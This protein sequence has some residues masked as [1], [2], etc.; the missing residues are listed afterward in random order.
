MGREELLWRLGLTKMIVNLVYEDPSA[1]L[2]PTIPYS[3]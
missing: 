3:A 2:Q 1:K